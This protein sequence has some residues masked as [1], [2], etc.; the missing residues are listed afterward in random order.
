MRIISGKYRS[1]ILQS[2]SGLETR[3]T[4]D[5]VKEA[6]FNHL[7]NLT[8]STFLDLCCG[9]GA[10][11]LEALS[12]GA[13]FVVFNDNSKAAIEV[14]KNN[15]RHLKIKDDE[16]SLYQK[17][18]LALLKS[19]DQVFEVIYLDPPFKE[20]TFYQQLLEEIVNKQLLSL[21]GELVVESE[22]DLELS[23]TGLVKTKTANYGRI[24][25]TYFKRS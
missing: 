12:R 15:I 11:G 19:L 13:K 17:D 21:N 4:L 3:P 9:S 1:L 14:V 22:K 2:L 5:N 23:V 25:I 18:A 6:V 20:A 10:I 7:G 8:D 24:K 16:Y